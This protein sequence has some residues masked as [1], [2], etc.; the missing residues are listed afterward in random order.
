[1][2]HRF[3]DYHSTMPRGTGVTHLVQE[4]IPCDV[5]I[6][7]CRGNGAGTLSTKMAQLHQVQRGQRPVA[8]G[9]SNGRVWKV[10][11]KSIELN[12]FSWAKGLGGVCSSGKN[13]YRFFQVNHHGVFPLS[14]RG[15]S[16]SLHQTKKNIKTWYKC[17]AIAIFWRSDQ[18]LKST[19]CFFGGMAFSCGH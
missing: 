14:E 9:K 12:S 3:C 5:W 10:K 16:D 4:I 7:D 2:F 18:A 13:I 8:S 19:T 11:L 1:M 17:E 15:K 6:R